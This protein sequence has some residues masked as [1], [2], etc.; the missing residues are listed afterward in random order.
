MKWT[1]VK[2]SHL[3]VGCFYMSMCYADFHESEPF[4]KVD[5]QEAASLNDQGIEVIDIKNINVEQKKKGGAKTTNT[6]TT[7]VRC[8]YRASDS[9]EKPKTKW[10]MGI[11]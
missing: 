1:L 6:T 4:N 10:T 2:L 11:E 8:W 7:Y 5:D 9:L 3:V